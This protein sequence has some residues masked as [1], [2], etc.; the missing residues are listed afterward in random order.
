MLAMKCTWRDALLDGVGDDADRRWPSTTAQRAAGNGPRPSRRF[1]ACVSGHRAIVQSAQGSR[2]TFSPRRPSTR[3]RTPTIPLRDNSRGPWTPP[4][5]G[6]GRTT[7]TIRR[8]DSRISS[9]T[10]RRTACPASPASSCRLTALGRPSVA[11]EQNP[12][13]GGVRH[14]RG[15]MVVLRVR[16]G[17]RALRVRALGQVLGLRGGQHQDGDDVTDYGAEEEA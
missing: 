14:K 1:G 8:A 11:K 5:A 4:S 6:S 17:G 10:A 7:V 9:T 3:S 12:E 2:G 15:E 16:L 13:R